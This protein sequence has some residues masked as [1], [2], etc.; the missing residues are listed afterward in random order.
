MLRWLWLSALV[1][2]LDQTT[3][4]MASNWLEPHV[5]YPLLSWFNLTLVHNT[6][7]AFSFLSGA[8]GWQ[9]WFFTVLAMGI[10]ILIVV[11][12]ARL[13]PGEC[14]SAVGLAMILGGAIGNLIDRLAYGYVI[15]FIQWYYDR[16]YWP[17]FN[18]A[19][20]AISVGAG[21]LVLHSL[22]SQKRES[23]PGATG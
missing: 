12:L 4:W 16:Y 10:G 13:R 22:F 6:G 2:I 14:W 23:R 3:K 17:T 5:Q 19:D 1:V 20:S 8:S 11:W 9:R 15:D 7:A 21:I 18:I